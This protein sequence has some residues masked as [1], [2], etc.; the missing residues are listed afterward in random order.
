MGHRDQQPRISSCR[1]RG[2]LE[3][4]QDPVLHEGWGLLGLLGFA[5]CIG[6][7]NTFWNRTQD[8]EAS[9]TFS[10]ESIIQ[11]QRYVQVA[12]GLKA[13]PVNLHEI[14]NHTN[15]LVLFCFAFQVT[16][17]TS[18][19]VMHGHQ[20]SLHLPTGYGAND[21]D[22]AGRAANLQLLDFATPF[23]NI[24]V[25]ATRR[26]SVRMFRPDG[27]EVDGIPLDLPMDVSIFP[28][29]IGC[30]A[31]LDLNGRVRVI[32]YDSK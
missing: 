11:S 18:R 13:K 10:K 12:M 27:R 7:P 15:S 3:E 8:Q 1:R 26:H 29:G 20:P 31:A 28:G 14:L 4:C 5:I 30:F 16:C 22:E 9:E 32:T 24:I 2:R 21:T 17:C 23:W 25:C 19:S 6:Q